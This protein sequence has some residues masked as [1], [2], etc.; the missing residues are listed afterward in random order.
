MI[1]ALADCDIPILLRLKFAWRPQNWH[2]RVE[3][4]QYPLFSL[5][6]SFCPASAARTGESFA[7]TRHIHSEKV[8][9]GDTQRTALLPINATHSSSGPP[10]YQR[11]G[12][13][14]MYTCYAEI[15]GNWT[16][17]GQCT[18]VSSGIQVRGWRRFPLLYLP[19]GCPSPESYESF[20]VSSSSLNVKRS[21]PSPPWLG[22]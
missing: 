22:R 5:M 11:D 13:N 10:S 6:P 17:F 9:Y 19:S 14:I 18:A 20:F 15:E 21:G 4:H 3:L 16:K 7:V 12:F 2:I 1:H 8:V